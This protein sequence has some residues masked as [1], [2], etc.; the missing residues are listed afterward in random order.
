[1]LAHIIEVARVLLFF[2]REQQIVLI[3]TNKLKYHIFKFMQNNFIMEFSL[4]VMKP[5]TQK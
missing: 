1:M 3:K 4:I 2:S 5:L